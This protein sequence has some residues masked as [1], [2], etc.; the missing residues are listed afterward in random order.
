MA[1]A[2]FAASLDRLT[3]APERYGWIADFAIVDA[4]ADD[5]AALAADP[6]IA[7]V[8]VIDATNVNV[9]GRRTVGASV[10]KAVGDVPVPLLSGRLPVRA[11]TRPR[12]AA[13]RPAGSGRGSA[14]GSPCGRTTSKA[15]GSRAACGSSGSRSRR[16]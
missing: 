14:T 8:A 12:W 11:A 15:S 2:S 10:R 3:K 16:R 6:R 4:K 1:V 13:A 5:A 7:A 9:D